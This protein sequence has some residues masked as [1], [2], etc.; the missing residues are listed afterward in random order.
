VSSTRTRPERPPEF[1]SETV[2]LVG[3][4]PDIER[5]AASAGFR[6]RVVTPEQLKRQYHVEAA[7]LLLVVDPG[8]ALRYAG[9]NTPRK[10]GYELHDLEIVSALAAGKPAATLP[11][12]AAA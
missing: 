5:R 4:H 2:L 9:G 3:G 11:L 7:P 12:Y 10:Q 6:L 1:L 8:G